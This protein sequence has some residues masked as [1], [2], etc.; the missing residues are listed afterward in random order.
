[1]SAPEPGHRDAFDFQDAG[2]ASHADQEVPPGGVPRALREAAELAGLDPLASLYNEALRYAQEGHLRL[3]RERLQM[4]LCMA[5][6]DGDARLMLS[7]VFVAEQDWTSALGALDEAVRCGVAVPRMLREAVEEHL[8]AERTAGRAEV[9][10]SEGPRDPSEVKALR[11]EARRLRS[12]NAQQSGQ[13]TQLEREV[14]KWAW[15]TAA[16]SVLA[17]AFIVGSLVL[18]ATDTSPQ[19]EPA[20]EPLL[21]PAPEPVAA[22]AVA[23]AAVA[24]APVV[25]PEPVVEP[26]PVVEPEPAPVVAP[27]PPP[28]PVDPASLEGGGAGG[29]GGWTASC[30]PT[31]SHRRRGRLAE[32]HRRGAEVRSGSGGRRSGRRP[33]SPGWR[34]STRPGWSCSCASAGPSTPCRR[35]TRFSVPGLRVLRQLVAGRPIQEANGV[36]ANVLRIGQKLTIPPLAR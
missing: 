13:I 2:R 35:A 32:H 17:S 9:T 6:D 25:E 18:G 10:G 16:V 14:R 31:G 23:P 20:M 7:R 30:R 36:Q 19:V 11:L 3:A 27:A 28:A 5:P 12:E 21:E 1:M 34:A 4:L 8:R 29:A 24:P 26:A 33:G 15:A 22:P